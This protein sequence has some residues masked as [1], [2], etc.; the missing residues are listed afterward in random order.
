MDVR[1]MLIHL[2]GVLDRIAALGNDDDPVS[3]IETNSPDDGWSDAW[4]TAGKR[5]ADAGRDDAMLERPMALPWIQGT[6]AEVLTSYFSPA[7]IR[8]LQDIDHS[9]RLQST[10]PECGRS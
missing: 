3:V 10:R 5:G 4:A 7:L 2:V 8:R 6:A 1:V 9:G